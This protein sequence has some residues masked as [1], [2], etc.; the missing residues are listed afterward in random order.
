MTI[1]EIRVVLSLVAFFND[2]V[3]D[4]IHEQAGVLTKMLL[5][6]FEKFV[7]TGDFVNDHVS[8]GQQSTA[9]FGFS[10]GLRNDCIGKA[11][12]E[13]FIG[14]H[15]RHVLRAALADQDA[16]RN[17]VL[18]F[19]IVSAPQNVVDI[20]SAFRFLLADFSFDLRYWD[21]EIEEHF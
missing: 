1:G 19:R 18:L 4:Q 7:F 10:S 17:G 20:G 16:S 13:G 11:L 2:Q 5:E 12:E 9:A 8:T 14:V 3:R 6:D 21:K 15:L